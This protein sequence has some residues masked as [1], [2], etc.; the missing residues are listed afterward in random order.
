MTDPLPEEYGFSGGRGDYGTFASRCPTAP[1]FR[2]L[3]ISDHVAMLAQINDGAARAAAQMWGNA[4]SLFEATRQNMVSYGE[5]LRQ[6]W[7]SQA[8]EPFFTHVGGTLYSLRLWA[9][10]ARSNQAALNRLGDAI[11]TAQQQMAALYASFESEV[12]A[13]DKNEFGPGFLGDEDEDDMRAMVEEKT[14]QSRA[15]METLAQQFTQ[16]VPAV[17]GRFA[18]PADARPPS[19]AQMQRALSTALGGAPQAPGGGGGAGGGGAG[20]GAPPAAPSMQTQAMMTPLGGSMA[21]GPPPAAPVRPPGAAPEGAR[22]PAPAAP[23][24]PVGGPGAFGAPPAAP[25]IG[26]SGSV[27]GP[28]RGAPPAA[29]TIGSA[30]APSS[31]LAGKR[32]APPAA[33]SRG[34]DTG[35]AQSLRGAPPE[36]AGAPPMGASNALQGR[37][38]PPTA[39]MPPGSG[40]RAAARPQIPGRAGGPGVPGMGSPGS[41]G[42]GPG[43]PG[44]GSPGSRGAA[45]RPGAPGTGVPGAPGLQG[46]Q[47]GRPAAG[48]PGGMAPP[49]SGVPRSLQGSR[50][51][52][53]GARSGRSVNGR[54]PIGPGM[55]GSAGMQGLRGRSG[56]VRAARNESAQTARAA[57]RRGLDGRGIAAGR[58]GPASAAASG[59]TGRVAN[60]TPA[61]RHEEKRAA[62]A[63]PQMVGDEKLF[64]V[65][66]AAPAVIER[67]QEKVHARRPGPAL[68]RG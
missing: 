36:A 58:S 46:R 40:A 18:G 27:S 59:P 20:R 31:G 30:G 42:A 63:V 17:E 64:A 3:L 61:R 5:G 33:P 29:P 48:S 4:A 49:S 65:D 8:A 66:P 68:G 35:G 24:M 19:E 28:V 43:V 47:A 11:Q 56:P 13:I 7:R 45:G 51:T 39:A 62:A 57:L 12:I 53:E 44:M 1:D 32:G 10:A 60:A 9:D 38:A 23:M 50:G 2:P 52:P 37:N 55:P 25:V 14:A 6:Q 16:T 41:R 67:K 22:G 15:I 26:A 54:A 34:S 21:L